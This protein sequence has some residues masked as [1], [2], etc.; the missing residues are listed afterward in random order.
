MIKIKTQIDPHPITKLPQEVEIAKIEYLDFDNQ[1]AKVKFRVHA[2]DQ[3]GNRIVSNSTTYEVW[4]HFTNNVILDTQGRSINETNYPKGE[5]ETD[6][7]YQKRI[8]ELK[9]KGIPEFTFWVSPLMNILNQALEQGKHLLD[10]E[11]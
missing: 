11:Q 9:S 2:L 8:D 3:E 1:E 7:D 6:E 10:L 4:E 5:S